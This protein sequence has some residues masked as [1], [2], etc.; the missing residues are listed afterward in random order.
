M[1]RD[2]TA[3]RVAASLVAT[4][5]ALSLTAAARA[6]PTIATGSGLGNN[7]Y[8]P[9][10]TPGWWSPDGRR[11]AFLRGPFEH[12][13]LALMKRS[14]AG[15]RLFPGRY[16]P[17][18]SPDGGRM[19][20]LNGRTIWLANGDGSHRKRIAAGSSAAWSPD[21]TLLA[22][23]LRG[24]LHVVNRDGTGLRRLPIEVPTCPTCRSSEGGPAWSPDGRTLAFEHGEAEPGSKGVG[25][26]WAGD[27]DGENIRRLSDWF[28]AYGP[29]WSP[30][31]TKV[32]YL[33]DDGFG[34]VSYLHIVNT[35]GSGDRRYRPASTFTWAPRGGMLAYESSASPK[36]VYLV[37]PGGR[38]VDLR[39]AAAPAWAP[40]GVRIAF[41]R[42]GSVFVAN[43]TGRRQRRIASGIAPSWSPDGRLIA[44]A[45]AT[46]GA[47]QGIHLVTPTGTRHGRLTDFCFIVGT[48]DRDRLRGT[49]G[50]DR[51]LAG[52]GNDLIVS[53][54]HRRD[55]VSCGS[56]LDRVV[57]DQLDQLGGCE[58][59]ER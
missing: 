36:H 59:I 23:D 8:Y 46:C 21:G 5:C 16:G 25:A 10:Q 38:S 28:N 57:A 20:L 55:I 35:D 42:R 54:D 53:R 37:R 44:Y 32:A 29:R 58:R 27:V 51:V 17:L 11:L 50:T 48:D 34:D 39:R 14:G 2:A 15:L 31:G 30:D 12:S 45:G 24:R 26:I 33:M 22:F 4:V 3:L 18:W 47:Q 49:A 43:A 56:G 7:G 41:Q 13:S 6:R 52:P 9:D 40:D 19:A 1:A